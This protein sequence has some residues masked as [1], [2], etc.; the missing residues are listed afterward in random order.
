MLHVSNGFLCF[1]RKS[2]IFPRA[3]DSQPMKGEG[4]VSVEDLMRAVVPYSR[5]VHFA[6]NFRA[7]LMP[8]PSI[9]ISVHPSIH[10][11]I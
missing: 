6:C 1:H 11:F 2:C 8:M 10:I 9:H 7:S 4:K 5:N 3:A